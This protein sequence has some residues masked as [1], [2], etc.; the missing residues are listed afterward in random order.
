MMVFMYLVVDVMI[1]LFCCD[2]IGREDSGM[3]R[4]W[5]VVVWIRLLSVRL[6]LM[7]SISRLYGAG[8][9]WRGL[10]STFVYQLYSV[11]RW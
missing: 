11:S 5:P 6:R 3:V 7:S 2:L 9:C 8:N 10:R 1:G 4:Y